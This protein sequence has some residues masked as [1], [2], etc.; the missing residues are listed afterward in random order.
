MVWVA[1]LP[2]MPY[3]R[4]LQSGVI[5]ASVVDDKKLMTTMTMKE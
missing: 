4:I 2:D 5:T 3:Y 1:V